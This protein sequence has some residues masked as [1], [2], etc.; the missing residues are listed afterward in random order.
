MDARSLRISNLVLFAED[1]SVFTVKEI[2]EEGL[3]VFN[4]DETT[5]IEIDQ[6]EG[7]P[8]TEGWLLRMGFV[9]IKRTGR[10]GDIYAI[11]SGSDSCYC[12][13]KDWNDYPS[14]FVGIEYTDS[15]FKEDED[16]TYNFSFDMKHVHQLQN[17]Y[18]AL[19]GEELTIKNDY[20]YA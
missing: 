10:Y 3:W 20:E 18:Y 9:R 7:I 1:Q 8:L 12:L 5:W 13:E 2:S 19:T 16:K 15:P 17:M 14:Y 4:E 11:S 6:F